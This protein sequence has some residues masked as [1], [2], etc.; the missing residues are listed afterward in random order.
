MLSRIN[1]DG[2]IQQ[3]RLN[4][5]DEAH[6]RSALSQAAPVSDAD[7]VE[8]VAHGVHARRVVRGIRR[9]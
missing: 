7:F 8:R 6:L 5:E 2:A 9:G 4:V 3:L 1:A